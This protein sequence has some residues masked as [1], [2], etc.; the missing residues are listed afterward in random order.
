MSGTSASIASQIA[1]SCARRRHI[2]NRRFCAGLL[3]RLGDGVED[4]QAEMSR[5]S[6]PG[7][8]PLTICA[9][10]NRLL[11]ME[12]AILAGEALGDDASVLVDEDGHEAPRVARVRRP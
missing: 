10:S 2:D 5:A 3:A 9:I 1:A 6:L 8:T 7:E 12:R 11:G 4:W